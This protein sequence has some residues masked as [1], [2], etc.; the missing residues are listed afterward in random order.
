MMREQVAE[1]LKALPNLRVLIV[2]DE[3]LVSLMIEAMLRDLGHEPAGRAQSVPQALEF[4]EASSEAMDAALLDVNLAG[5]FVYP[6][7]QALTDKEIPFAFLTGYGVFGVPPEF[8]HALVMQKP[9]SE[10][11]VS[12]AVQSMQRQ[13]AKT[14]LHS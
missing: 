13:I 4:L 10:R 12:T 7:A 8:S 11:D 5:D 1:T 6:V 9:F 2:E 3:A 14:H